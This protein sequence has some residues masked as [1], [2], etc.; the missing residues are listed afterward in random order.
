MVFFLVQVCQSPSVLPEIRTKEKSL[1][2]GSWA[3][4][5]LEFEKH[6]LELPADEI[7]DDGGG[8]NVQELR[9]EKMFLIDSIER[10]DA[11]RLEF[12]KATFPPV[13]ESWVR[14]HPKDRGA[15]LTGDLA[16]DPP[17]SNGIEA[18]HIGAER[19]DARPLG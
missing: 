18:V 2:R 12:I 16:L 13:D 3:N 11:G 17:S 15:L 5:A 4:D 19:D 6:P 10:N 1:L 8:L 14:F 7:L 9:V